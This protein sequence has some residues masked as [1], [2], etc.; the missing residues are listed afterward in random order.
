MA[1]GKAVAEAAFRRD[2]RHFAYPFGDRETW[3]RQ[4]VAMAQETG[5]ASAVTTLPGIVE[6]RGRSDL[7]A[8]PRVA[9]NGRQR[10]LRMMR[11]ILSGAFFAQTKVKQVHL[12]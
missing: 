11:V 4:H 3:R 5:Y 1:M 9:W 8:L 7:F 12:G 6:T 10:S 2:I